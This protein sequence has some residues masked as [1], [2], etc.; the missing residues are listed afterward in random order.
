MADGRETLGSTGSRPA[1]R[2]LAL[3]RSISSVGSE[4]AWIAL[5]VVVLRE[6][7]STVWLAMSLLLTYGVGGLAGPFT[8][9]LGDRLPRRR[10]MIGS[11]LCG[12][13]LFA[14]L[15]FMHGPAALL[16]V[17][18]AAVVVESP[19]WSAADAAIPNVAGGEDLGWANG[20]V[21]VGR[22]LG[23]VVG[24]PLGGVLVSMLG[25][26]WVFA[27]NA[28]S[29]AVSAALV[30]TVRGRFDAERS[31]LDVERHRGPLAGLAFVVRDRILRT[32]ALAWIVFAL[33]IGMV[34]VADLPL[35]RKF[36]TGAVGFG[37]ISAAWGLGSIGGS[38]AGRWLNERNEMVALVV[39]NAGLGLICVGIW[40]SGWFALILG[41]MGAFGLLEGIQ[42]VADTSIQ[43][44]RAPDAVRSR[45]M[46]AR[47]GMVN[48]VMA[49]SFLVGGVVIRSVGPQGVYL[50]AAVSIGVSTLVLLPLVR[51]RLGVTEWQS[52]DIVVGD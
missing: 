5:A 31:D 11:D 45:A 16:A 4:A 14:V 41:L 10:V 36:G 20:L 18:F 40:R 6:T 37:L 2:R 25:G 35:A 38:L 44:R 43:Q 23:H 19:F 24:P 51:T 1:V 49:G 33:G 9:M 7:G 47:E 30:A 42:E 27:L 22:N 46:A 39:T 26:S 12:A 48:V 8:A 52:N 21:A 13:A 50:L 29:F 3:A 34:V 28:A 32:I 17:A 15:A